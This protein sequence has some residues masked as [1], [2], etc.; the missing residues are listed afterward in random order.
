MP[1]EYTYAGIFFPTVHPL[2]YS[3]MTKIPV[4]FPDSGKKTFLALAVFFLLI[5]QGDAPSLPL[6]EGF[7]LSVV[8]DH[9]KAATMRQAA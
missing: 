4:F 9:A 5:Q 1:G 8:G 6:A 3:E 7:I 2:F